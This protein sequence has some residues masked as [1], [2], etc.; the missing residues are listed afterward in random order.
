MLLVLLALASWSDQ[1]TVAVYDYSLG[2][3]YVEDANPDAA[4]CSEFRTYYP[5]V[6]A[7]MH[8]TCDWQ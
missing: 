8:T 3:C 5:C 1:C 6:Y 7:G 2:Q 4:T